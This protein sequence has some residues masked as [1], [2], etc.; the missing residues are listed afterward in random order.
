LVTTLAEPGM[1][2]RTAAPKKFKL[3]FKV[4]EKKMPEW[5]VVNRNA[6]C[7]KRKT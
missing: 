2:T 3:V 5:L 4:S 1:V 7:K 6:L